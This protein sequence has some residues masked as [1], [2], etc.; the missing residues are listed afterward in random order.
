MDYNTR[1]RLKESIDVLERSIRSLRVEEVRD[2]DKREADHPPDNPELI[3]ERLYTRQRGLYDG[4][5]A[6]PVGGHRE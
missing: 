3:P 6:N 5:V 2:R 1:L 4:I